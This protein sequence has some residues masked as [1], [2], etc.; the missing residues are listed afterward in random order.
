[1]GKKTR[2][3]DKREVG[4]MKEIRTCVDGNVTKWYA[5]WTQNGRHWQSRLFNTQAEAE[6]YE[7]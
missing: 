1:M 6:A 7:V 5:A 3:H 4:K 2:K